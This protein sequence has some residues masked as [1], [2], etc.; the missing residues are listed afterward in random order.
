VPLPS[1]GP[2]E[3]QT[4]PTVERIVETTRKAIQ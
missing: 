3:D 1:A 2:L 4:I